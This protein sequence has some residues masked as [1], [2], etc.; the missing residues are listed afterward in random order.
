MKNLLGIKGVRVEEFSGFFSD[1]Y[2]VNKFLEAHDGDIIDI[3]CVQNDTNCLSYL[4]VYKESEEEKSGLT[5]ER[6]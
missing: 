5:E 2:N 1:A 4:V 6:K 3:M